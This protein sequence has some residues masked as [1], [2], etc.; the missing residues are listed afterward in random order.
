VTQALVFGTVRRAGGRT[1]G[2][3]QDVVTA[4]AIGV[5]TAAI[6]AIGLWYT[7][8]RSALERANPTAEYVSSAA[9]REYRYRVKNVGKYYASDLRPWLKD[10]RGNVVSHEGQR[11]GPDGKAVAQPEGVPL[12]LALQPNESDEFL[13]AVRDDAI[14]RNPL[15]LH[16]TWVDIPDPPLVRLILRRSPYEQRKKK[17]KA[18]VP[19]S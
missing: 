12:F 5:I 16:F 17:S 11:I 13:I 6:A 19:D 18:C 4:V 15:D 7:I 10:H 8:R 9:G 2:A 1:S 14:D 3:I